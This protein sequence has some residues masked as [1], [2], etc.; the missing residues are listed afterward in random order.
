MHRA[1]YICPIF[2][3]INPIAGVRIGLIDG[4]YL[5]NPTFDERRDSKLDLIVAGTEEAIVMVEAEA[6]EVEEKIMVEAMMLAHKEIKRLCL[7]QKE[8][9]KALGIKKR[10]I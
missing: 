1:L 6:R 5:I 3:L 4:K 9:C 7:W 2:R 10:D 8:L